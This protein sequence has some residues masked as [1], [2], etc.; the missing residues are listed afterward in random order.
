L[1]EKGFDV[2]VEGRIKT[3]YSIAKKLQR[4]HIPLS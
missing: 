1:L 3:I 4:K 2:A